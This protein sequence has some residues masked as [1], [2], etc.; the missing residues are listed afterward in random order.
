MSSFER[1]CPESGANNSFD[2]TRCVKCRAPLTRP[3]STEPPP[4]AL[5]SR[6]MMANLAWKATKFLARQGFFLAVSGAKRGIGRVQ[7][8]NHE[9][10]SK[11][12]IEGDFQVKSDETALS[13]RNRGA[14]GEWRV[15]SAPPPTDPDRPRVTWGKKK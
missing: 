5:L 3:A 1:I 13:I 14:S 7:N 15:W 2:K 8:R 4:P 12:T 10:V 6:A 9:D 11:E